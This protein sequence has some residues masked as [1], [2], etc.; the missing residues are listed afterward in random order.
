MD[1][2]ITAKLLYC[3]IILLSIH[4]HTHADTQT[5]KSADMHTNMNRCSHS[6]IFTH[7]QCIYSHTP[8]H[9][10]TIAAITNIQTQKY[11]GKCPTHSFKGKRRHRHRN[12][13][14]KTIY[15]PVQRMCVTAQK[16]VREKCRRGDSCREKRE[17]R[18]VKDR[19]EK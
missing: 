3:C 14:P 18:K 5:H 1:G 11:A 10:Q 13:I 8:T 6:F 9:K 4:T 16:G 19:K 17:K 7:V 12:I 2:Q 15:N